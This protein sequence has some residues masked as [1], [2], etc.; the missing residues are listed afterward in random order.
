M[1]WPA[2]LADLNP[3]ELVWIEL[4][5]K[6]RAKQST[7]VAHLWQLLQESWTELS[8]VLLQSLGERMPGICEAVTVRKSV[9]LMKLLMCL[10]FYLYLMWLRKTYTHYNKKQT[11]WCLTCFMKNNTFRMRNKF[12]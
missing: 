8:S 6:V 3:I 11:L 1:S 10:F 12:S 4:D 5:R 2:Q 7:S 9:I